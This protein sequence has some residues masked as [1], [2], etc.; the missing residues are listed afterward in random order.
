MREFSR[1]VIEQIGYYVYILSDPDT[2]K[3]FYVGKGK[4]NRLFAHVN[5]SLN[6]P[7]ENDKLQQI[8]DII[9]RGQD[10]KFEVLR[11][12]M[13]EAEAFEVEAAIIDY[14]GIPILANKAIGHKS[15]I[16]GRMGIADIIAIYSAQPLRISEPAVLIIINKLWERNISPEKL[17]EITNGDWVM[18]E[19]RNKAKYAFAVYCGVVRE[20]YQI[21]GWELVEGLSCR[22]LGAVKEKLAKEAKIQKRWKF[23]GIIAQQLQHYIGGSVANYLN[24]GA[25]NPIRYINC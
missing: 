12:G 11:H 23:N 10:V 3:P 7:T 16:R 22:N 2:N 6:E 4:G 1:E 19:R 15:E 8:R 17:Y 13:T 20:V 14:I 18:G 25:Q 5:D 9:A 24:R 21:I